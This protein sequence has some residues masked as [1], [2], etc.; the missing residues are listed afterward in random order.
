MIESHLSKG[1]VLK[2]FSSPAVEFLIEHNE[3]YGLFPRYIRDISR[4][5]NHFQETIVLKLRYNFKLRTNVCPYVH[6]YMRDMEPCIELSTSCFSSNLYCIST[7]EQ[8]I[9]FT[10]VDNFKEFFRDEILKN[11]K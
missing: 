4:F 1:I 10:D 6:V 11:R 2:D 8:Y 9:I 3:E 7:M 5:R